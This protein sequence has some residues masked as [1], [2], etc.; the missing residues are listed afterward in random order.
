MFFVKSSGFK[1]LN[2]S[3]SV[4]TMQQSAFLRHST[5]DEAYSILVL[6][7]VLVAGMAA[8]S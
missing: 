2:S 1:L 8:G 7:M 6:S 5:A 3:H 4:T